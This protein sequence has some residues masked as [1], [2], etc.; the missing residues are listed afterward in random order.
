MQ[1]LTRTTALFCRCFQQLP[2]EHNG[3]EENSKF[4]Q[5]VAQEELKGARGEGNRRLQPQGFVLTKFEK[6]AWKNDFNSFS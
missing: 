2:K 5:L 1:R 6:V 3:E 4:G